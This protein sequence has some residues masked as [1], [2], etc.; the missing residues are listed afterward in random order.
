MGFAQMYVTREYL[1]YHLR[2]GEHWLE[3]TRG[4]WYLTFLVTSLVSRESLFVSVCLQNF[5]LG[6]FVWRLG[7]RHSTYAT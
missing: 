7:D 6:V 3:D 5:L 2:L 1:G 4:T